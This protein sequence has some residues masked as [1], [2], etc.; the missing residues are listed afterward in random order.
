M[1]RALE[2]GEYAEVSPWHR[3]QPA[4]GQKDARSPLREWVRSKDGHLRR[5]AS[6]GTRPRLPWAPRLKAARDPQWTL[7]LLEPIVDDDAE[8]VRRS[9]SNH[10]NDLCREDEELGLRV[11]EEWWR[12]AGSVAPDDAERAERVRW[13]VR[14]GLRSLVKGGHAKAL[15]LLGHDPDANVDAQGF[16][17]ETP[18]VR[19]GEVLRF[20]LMLVSTDRDAHRVVLDYAIGFPLADGTP[21]RKVFKWTTLELAAGESRRLERSQSIRPVTTRTARAGRH[22]LEVQANGRIVARGSF[23]LR[24][25]RGSG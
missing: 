14:R 11:A 2:G 1:R 23:Q 20:A 5:L 10:L 4:G 25:A 17:V 16:R 15:R 18:V 7:E 13:V 3:R 6:E 19:L 24:I 8:Y 22:T 12:R 21:A 9:V